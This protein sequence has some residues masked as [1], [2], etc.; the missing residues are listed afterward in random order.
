[1]NLVMKDLSD[2]RLV[3]N[4]MHPFRPFGTLRSYDPLHSLQLVRGD[5][6]HVWDGGG[7]RYLDMICGY[8]ACN[9]GHSHPRL[10][11]AAI[12]QLQT[13]AFANGAESPWRDALESRLAGLWKSSQGVRLPGDRASDVKVWLCTTGARGVELAWRV[14][15]AVRPGGVA[16]FDLGYHGRSMGSAMISDTARSNSLDEKCLHTVVLPFPRHGVSADGVPLVCTGEECCVCDEAFAVAQK[17]LSSEVDRLSMLIVEPAIGA[18]GYWFA[19]VR[20]YRR[21]I[22]FAKRLGLVVVSDEIQMG[23][24]RLG[25]LLVGINDGWCPDMLVLGKSLG[26][27]MV[28][29]SAVLGPGDW[30]DRLPAAIESETFAATP[31]ACRIGDEVLRVMEEEVM[32]TAKLDEG[33]REEADGNRDAIRIG[34]G[35]GDA[36]VSVS[37]RFTSAG[38]ITEADRPK[39]ERHRALTQKGDAFRGLLRDNMPE[40]VRIE[41]RGMASVLSFDALGAHGVDVARRF[42]M[43]L[44][45]RGVLAHLTGPRRD[46]LALIPPLNIPEG[47]LLDAVDL[48]AAASRETLR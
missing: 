41:G 21:L 17:M 26:G 15:T 42:T 5:G 19:S 48:F 45:D 14:A 37:T 25:P 46:R 10:V 43:Q 35:G 13:L 24:G 28:P 31:L 2:E 39:A 3:R 30:M 22:E 18:R 36:C 12:E 32:D 11:S 20:Y 4:T 1:M 6:P 29:I 34:D 38:T 27:G 7:Q 23:L 8:S 40:C 33:D 16:R 9:L 47:M 44:C